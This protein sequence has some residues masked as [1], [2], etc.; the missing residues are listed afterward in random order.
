MIDSE[1]TP[2]IGMTLSQLAEVAAEAG[3][4]PFAA[5]QMARWLYVKRVTAI[6]AMTD[7]PLQAR[8]LLGER[9]TV[10]RE[11]WLARVESVDGTAKYLF[12]GAGECNVES[13]MIPDGD[14]AT[15]C[16]SSQAGCKMGCTF[17]MTGRQGFHGQLTAAQIINQVLSVAESER[18]TNIVFMGMGEPMDN[19]PQVLAAIEILTAPWGFAWSP[20]RIT[21][22]SIGRIDALRTLIETTGVH[23]AI[24]LHS[25]FATEREQLMPVERAYPIKEVLAMLRNYDWTHQRRLSIEYIMWGGLNDDPR[26]ADALVRLL[27]GL[28][29]RVNLIRFHAIPGSRLR[30]S[31]ERNMIAFR[32]R[33]NAHGITATIR[34]S[35]GE[36][37]MAACGML[38]GLRRQ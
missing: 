5:R 3:L 24:S 6:D 28:H 21:V 13:V 25:P 36:D 16:V 17:C 10:G 32:D 7:L 31:S 34:A 38:A 14:R 37:I 15:L 27:K 30:T 22:S 18:L 2:L 8:S 4:R 19:L 1:K 11:E 33:L 12:R 9:Y 29:C 35:R 26:H 23:V 20:K